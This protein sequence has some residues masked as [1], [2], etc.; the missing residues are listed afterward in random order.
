VTTDLLAAIGALAVLT[1]LP[2]PDVAVVTRVALERGRSSAVRT[3]LGIVSGLLVWGVLTVGGLSAVLAASATAYTVVKV[4]GGLFL[5]WLGLRTLL[6]H[7]AP[8]ARRVTTH[9]W[10]TGFVSNVLNPKIAAFYTGLLPQLVPDGAPHAAT[11]A[12]LVLAHAVL[13]LAFLS[14]YAAALTRASDLLRRPR[15]R[16]WLDRVSGGVLVAFGVRVAT[17]AR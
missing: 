6:G 13:S 12:G 4:A 3:A 15:V 11:L 7:G 5:V 8:D 9:P 10:R 1:V 16:R 17:A 14:L 2:G